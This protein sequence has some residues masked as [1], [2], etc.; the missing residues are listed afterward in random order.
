MLI[1]QWKLAGLSM[2]FRR[3][4]RRAGHNYTTWGDNYNEKWH[5]MVI[6]TWIIISEVCWPALTDKLQLTVGDCSLIVLCLFVARNCC[7]WRNITSS[8]ISTHR[9]SM[10]RTLKPNQWFCSLVSIPRVKRRSFATC[11][12]KTFPDCASVL[13]RRPIGL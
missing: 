8:M 4:F 9:R 3:T 7:R 6:C 13:S 1:M 12:S 10:S 2:S 5:L 11:W